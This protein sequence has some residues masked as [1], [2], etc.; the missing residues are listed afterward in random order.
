MNVDGPIPSDVPPVGKVAAASLD[1]RLL[2]ARADVAVLVRE[3][4]RK[5]TLADQ[6]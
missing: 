1:K 6:G 3:R 2:K 4:L 5:V